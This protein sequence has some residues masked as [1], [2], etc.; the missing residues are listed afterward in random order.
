MGK[1]FVYNTKV[2]H[3]IVIVAPYGIVTLL[4]AYGRTK[5]HFQKPHWHS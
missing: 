3:M 5:H 1:T 4:L 2:C